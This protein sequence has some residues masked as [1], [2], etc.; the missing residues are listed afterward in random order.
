LPVG[1]GGIDLYAQYVLLDGLSGSGD[2]IPAA[3]NAL[4]HSLGNQ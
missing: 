2:L 1:A 3:S 4:R